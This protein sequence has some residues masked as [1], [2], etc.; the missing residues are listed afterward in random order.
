M[1]PLCPASFAQSAVHLAPTTS[2][3]A[4]LRSGPVTLPSFSGQQQR[5]VV[6]SFVDFV[7]CKFVLCNHSRPPSVAPSIAE[8]SVSPP[9]RVVSSPYQQTLQLQPP[10]WRPVAQSIRAHN[11]FLSVARNFLLLAGNS[12]PPSSKAVEV[13]CTQ[14]F[15]FGAILS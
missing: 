11:R 15:F 4:E 9:P 2:T 6:L 8:V 1:L 13:L 7:I 12:D 14:T 3:P 10:S 5:L